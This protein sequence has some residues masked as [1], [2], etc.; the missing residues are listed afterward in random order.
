MCCINIYLP[1]NHCALTNTAYANYYTSL[2]Q[3]V[4]HIQI[5]LLF[6]SGTSISFTD[7]FMLSR[8]HRTYPKFNN[9]NKLI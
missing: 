8:I 9:V 7:L 5:F 2:L 3:N 4:V 1:V 6:F